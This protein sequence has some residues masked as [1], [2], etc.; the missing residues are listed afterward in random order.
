MGQQQMLLIILSIILVGIALTAGIVMF[1]SS[2]VNTNKDA[3]TNDLNALAANAY[4]FLI[5]PSQSG[6]GGGTYTGGAGYA[7]PPELQADQNGSYAGTNT[8][9]SIIFVATSA[10]GYGTVTAECDSSG[11]LGNFTYSGDFL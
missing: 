6:G 8:A 4:R 10:Q 9:K 2:V 1:T 5:R 11:R 7:I 3:L